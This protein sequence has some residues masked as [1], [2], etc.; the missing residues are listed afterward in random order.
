M[1]M[2]ESASGEG[3]R[4][5]INMDNWTTKKMV[6]CALVLT[7]CVAST[8]ADK[9]LTEQEKLAGFLASSRSEH[10][11]RVNWH[12]AASFSFDDASAMKDFRGQ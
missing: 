12:E 2:P 4:K 1:E 10:N 11:K 8:F 7:G 6:L 3:S 9:E 5:E